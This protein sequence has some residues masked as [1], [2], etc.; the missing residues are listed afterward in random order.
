MAERANSPS[1]GGRVNDLPSLWIRRFAPLVPKDGRVLDIACGSGRHTRLFLALGHPVTAVDVDLSRIRDLADTPR[2]E[3]I[4]A[5]L[6]GGRWPLPDRRFAAVVVVNYL[7]RPLFPALLAAIEP[8][9]VL[10]YETFAAGNAR[11]GRPAN[12]DHLLAAEELLERVRGTL[13]IVAYEHG[14]VGKPRPAAIERLA[15][16]KL[17]PGQD[18]LTPLP[19]SE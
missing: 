14:V 16:V 3:L 5:D 9:G 7:W 6:E 4:E 10:L 8:N 19:I 1:A 11:F 15:A 2:T 17:A 13:H 12:P 18:R